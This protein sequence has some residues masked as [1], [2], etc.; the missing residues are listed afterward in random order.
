MLSGV[1]AKFDLTQRRFGRLTVVAFDHRAAVP[2]GTRLFWRCHCDCGGHKTVETG[3]LKQGRTVS[4][5]HCDKPGGSRTEW[6]GYSSLKAARSRCDNPHNKAFPDYGGRGIR[7]CERWRNG[8][9]LK[10]GFECFFDDMGPRPDGMSLDR[11]DNDGDY[12]PGNCRW[13]TKRQQQQNQRR[14]IY[15]DIGGVNVPLTK[16]VERL[17]LTY[18]T[19]RFLVRNRGQTVG[20][21]ARGYLARAAS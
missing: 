18:E 17:G 19:I 15:A 7:V 8:D 4:C 13:A 12:E 14:A 3:R 21:A 5:G 9:G 20:D 6:P 16:Y 10:T 11:I 2:G 1:R